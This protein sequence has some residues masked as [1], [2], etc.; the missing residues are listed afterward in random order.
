MP[1]QGS[2]WTTRSTNPYLKDS[3]VKRARKRHTTPMSKPGWFRIEGNSTLGDSYDMYEVHEREDGSFY[4][5]CQGNKGGEYRS[6]CSHATGALL[7][8][9]DHGDPWEGAGADEEVS[10]AQVSEVWGYIPPAEG[11][12]MTPVQEEMVEEIMGEITEGTTPKSPDPL[13]PLTPESEL[14]PD[15]PPLPSQ[16]RLTDLEPE[17]PARF[18][19][20]KSHQWPAIVE[21]IEHLDNGVKVVFVEAP[22]GAGKTLIAESIRRLV[23][24]KAIYCCTTKTLQDQILRDFGEYGR[25]L[26]GKGNYP[27]LDRADLTADDCTRERTTLPA[28]TNCKGGSGGSWGGFDLEGAQEQ[29]HCAWCHPVRNCPYEVAKRDAITSR[30]AVLNTAYLLAETNYNS[31]S[32][33]KGW[34]LVL[35]DEADK[36]EEELMRFVEVT[37][38][39]RV[40]RKLGVGL[41]EKKTV[42]QSWI[43]WIADEVIPAIKKKLT[44][45][46]VQPTLT[47]IPDVQKE[48]E[49]KSLTR[50]LADVSSLIEMEEDEETGETR[51]VLQSGWVYT[52][53]EGKEDK[54]VTVTFKPVKVDAFAPDVLWNKAGQF[55]LLSAT[56]VSPQQLAED[57]GLDDGDWEYV[58][59][60]STF[61]VERRPII[62]LS[63]ASVTSKTKKEATPE[64]VRKTIDLVRGHP[65]ERVLIHSVSY[66][67]TKEIYYG[68]RGESD[69]RGRTFTYFTSKDRESALRNYLGRQDGVIIAPS[70]DRGV[71]LHGDDCRAIIVAKVPYPY[72]GDKQV[73]QRLY[74]TGR[75]GKIW[76]SVQTIRTICQMTGRGMRS[77][78]D[79]CVTY[80]LDSQFNRLFNENRRL[81][82]GWWASAL[83]WD[84]NDPK[85]RGPL[86][87][88]GAVV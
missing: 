10:A 66:E 41:P 79:S 32:R 25:V 2:S 68:L 73:S 65:G 75:S 49:R 50:L 8:V 61:P 27:T 4:C 9:Q 7:Y 22:T 74:G 21:I 52:G 24:T 72:V 64:I 83:V 34:P 14:D 51:M 19:E 67:L 13:T 5:T 31:R 87:K 1:V 69:L 47:G 42:D 11:V 82:P 59:V 28:C 45:T 85:W 60:P 56:F 54:Y 71:D 17:M 58:E 81:F 48:R 18:A 38:G 29:W 88:L 37:I 44:E 16:L 43:D 30:L 53:Y 80:I 84:E 23:P 26:K 78:D 76:Y 33:L 86:E 46:K 12:K 57:L 20:F 70:F 39:P 3:L 77:A 55:V 6:V 62:P 15:D 35:M 36:L 40:R 63:V